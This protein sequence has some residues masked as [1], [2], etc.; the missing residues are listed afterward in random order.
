ME[1]WGEY[2]N[3]ESCEEECEFMLIYFDCVDRACV[4]SEEGE[5]SSLESC[6]KSCETV[7]IDELNSGISFTINN[8]ILWVE[9]IG[10]KNV[11]DLYG[12]HLLSSQEH[13]INLKSL[14]SGVY[15]LSVEEKRVTFILEK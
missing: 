5:Y 14:A 11:Y 12:R 10:V 4:E 13:K 2:P 15:I 9:G 3:L 1:G 6:E 8:Q 7:A